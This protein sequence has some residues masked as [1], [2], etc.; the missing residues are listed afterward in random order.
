M[1][2]PTQNA[3]LGGET[4]PAK[5]Q[6]IVD[7]L[8][9]DEAMPSTTSRPVIVTNRPMVGGDPMISSQETPETPTSANSLLTAPPVNRQAKDVAPLH[10]AD[11][12]KTSEAPAPKQK[13][14]VSEEAEKPAEKI[15]EPKPEP[16]AN[17][18]VEAEHSKPMDK[19]ASIATVDDDQDIVETEAALQAKTAEQARQEELEAL[20]LKGTYHLPINKVARRKMELVL[21]SLLILL[22]LLAL[23]DLLLDMGLLK[24]SGVPHTNFFR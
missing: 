19:T 11:A 20:I 16:P 14:E 4:A 5:P 1:N 23:L 8:H 22:L 12:V 9:P 3:A 18:N 21:S 15:A 6:K 13:D 10:A 7:V 2:E 17:E 24:L